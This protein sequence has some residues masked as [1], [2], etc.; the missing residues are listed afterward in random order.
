MMPCR[1]VLRCV[2]TLV[3]VTGLA[4]GT[5]LAQLEVDVTIGQNDPLPIAVTKFHGTGTEAIVGASIAQV[6]SADL[7]RS[8]LFAPI[9]Q[10]A[11]IQRSEDIGEEGLPRFGDWRTI[12][13]QAL[14]TGWVTREA[15]GRI[16]VSFRLWDTFSEE[17]L[18][19]YVY[20]GGEDIWRRIAHK[21]SDAVYE[22]L[23]GEAGYFDTRIVYVSVSGTELE[24]IKRLAIMDQ[25]GTNH[26]YLTDGSDLALTPRFSPTEQEIT[27]VE[28]SDDQ[29][30]RVF[31]LELDT[32]RQEPLGNFEGM[33][34]A[35][36]FS[37]D[38][39]EVILSQAVNGNTDIY[40]MDLATLHTRRLTSDPAIDTS[41]SF[42]PD[43]N[44]VTFTSDRGGKTQ[45]YVMRS[46]GSGV[47][48]ITFGNGRYS[49]P[50]WSPRGDLIAFT[51]QHN[52]RF[53]IGVMNID[54]SGERLISEGYLV[55][56]P[57]WAPNGRVLMFLKESLVGA[58]TIEQLFTIDLTGFNER[59]VLTPEEGSDPAWSPLLP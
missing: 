55:D 34:F 54:G 5:A 32:G 18:D 10:A 23:T 6:V 44:F 1:T 16:K 59:V 4:P 13:A 39:R 45:I 38:G 41:P 27:Y 33:Y 43:G 19:G 11:F 47:Q 2:A 48:R 24:P 52:S 12:N 17:Q 49:T 25:D 42:S 56:S 26:R 21:I 3:L 51:K 40:I 30:A 9:E 57:T 58:Q 50:V 53:Y 7:E 8:G 37:P 46:D 36:R 31:L 14:I 22:R 35:P 29:S 20:R 15:D 28:L